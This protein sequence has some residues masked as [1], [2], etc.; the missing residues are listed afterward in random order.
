MTNNYLEL[1]QSDFAKFVNQDDDPEKDDILNELAQYA[2]EAREKITD[3][4]ISN[5]FM[6]MSSIAFELKSMETSSEYASFV[7]NGIRDMI[8]ARQMLIETK[9]SDVRALQLMTKCLLSSLKVKENICFELFKGFLTIDEKLQQIIIVQ[10]DAENSY[11]AF[12]RVWKTYTL[13]YTNFLLSAEQALDIIKNDSTLSKDMKSQLCSG[14]YMVVSFSFLG[15]N[16]RQ[17]KV[18]YLKLALQNWKKNVTC[19]YGLGYD[20]FKSAYFKMNKLEPDKTEEA[21]TEAAEY[22]NRCIKN[23]FWD[24]GVVKDSFVIL[25]WMN[26]YQKKD[27][28]ALRFAK[29]ARYAGNRMTKAMKNVIVLCGGIPVGEEL[30]KE[31]FPNILL[32]ILCDQCDKARTNC[33][34]LFNCPCKNAHYCCKDCQ[35]QDWSIHGKI[36]PIRKKNK[37]P[38]SE[39]FLFGRY[40]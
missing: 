13:F 12:L 22:F 33:E 5:K 10:T 2:L 31:R 3:R 37:K 35:K 26:L 40:N 15:D 8:S 34:T 6:D 17:E 14:V 28:M 1:K 19:L 29:E 11:A 16:C 24:D 27:D 7:N 32:T 30:F 21:W 25:S 23:S 9:Y 36:C 38:T 4:F 39:S 20:S 18:R